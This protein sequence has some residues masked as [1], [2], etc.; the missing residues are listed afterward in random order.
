ME[1]FKAD[2]YEGDPAKFKEKIDNRC[3]IGIKAKVLSFLKSTGLIYEDGIMYKC[4]LQVMDSLRISRVAYTQF[5]FDQLEHA[6][7]LY[8]QW[9]KND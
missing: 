3:H 2:K 1:Q 5:K 4:S 7:S 9:C 6:Y 8:L